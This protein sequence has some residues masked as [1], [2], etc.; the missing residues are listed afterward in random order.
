MAAAF[1][2]TEGDLA[3][4]LLATLWAAEGEGG[5]VRGRQSAALLVVPGTGDPRATRF[6]L[7]VED[8][9]TPLEELTRLLEVARAYEAFDRA[10]KMATEGDLTAAAGLMDQAHALAP[11]DDMI[12]LWT[13]VFIAGVGRIDDAR[14]LFAQ[15]SRVE[16][17]S[18]EHLRRFVAAGQLPPAAQA[19]IEMLAGPS[20]T[21]VRTPRS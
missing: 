14:E 8:D 3:G 10:E 19:I 13:S 6:D 12:T 7:R 4:R 21:G 11:D 9:R 20:T 17:R 1:R 16:P 5:D 15:A 2:S 18:A